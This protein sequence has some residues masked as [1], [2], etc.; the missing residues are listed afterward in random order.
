M[1]NEVPISPGIALRDALVCRLPHTMRL[2]FALHGCRV[3]AGLVHG[4]DAA[5]ET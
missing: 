3:V 2:G 1:C 5:A 4:S